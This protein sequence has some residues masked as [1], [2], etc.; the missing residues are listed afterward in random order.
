MT[1]DADEFIKNSSL[2]IFVPGATD[3]EIKE[4]F[5]HDIENGDDVNFIAERRGLLYFG[6]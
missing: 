5:T 6:M 1:V 3:V 4:L 2:E